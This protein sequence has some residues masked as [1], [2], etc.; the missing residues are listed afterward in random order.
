MGNN[1]SILIVEDDPSCSKIYNLFF[2]DYGYNVHLYH[3]A[4]SAIDYLTCIKK[5]KEL[6]V[7]SVLSDIDLPGEL[8]GIMLGLYVKS[9]LGYDFPFFLMSGYPM[10]LKDASRKG[11]KQIFS[12]TGK[13]GLENMF[14]TIDTA[15]KEYRNE[16]HNN[17]ILKNMPNINPEH[18]YKANKTINST[19]KDVFNTISEIQKNL[20][21][22]GYSEKHIGA[23]RLCL[24]EALMNAL[25][26]GSYELYGIKRFSNEWNNIHNNIESNPEYTKKP[27]YLS[28]DISAEKCK[29]SVQDT[30]K[31]VPLEKRIGKKPET[32]SVSG[33]G[34]FLMK[35]ILDSLEYN[36]QGNKIT[37]TFIPSTHKNKIC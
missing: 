29:F 6:N 26:Y 19:K 9:G 1:K 35:K 20:S 31:G 16:P 28:A 27:I 12:K 18:I 24:E 7:D 5:S 8:D 15:V 21:I 3:N 25:W 13:G 36:N 2:S 4:E 34:I 22:I 11:I 14:K 37:C 23:I 32:S 33:R 30:G 17:Q 10:M